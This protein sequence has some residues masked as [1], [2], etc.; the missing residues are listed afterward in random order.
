M[1]K[2]SITLQKNSTVCLIPAPGNCI[3]GRIYFKG[4]TLN[5]TLLFTLMH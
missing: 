2:S 4:V 1:K 5:V 3:A